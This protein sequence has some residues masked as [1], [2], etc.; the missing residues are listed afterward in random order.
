M[1]TTTRETREPR[2]YGNW[3]VPRAASLFGGGSFA[4]SVVLA[5]GLL[6]GIAAAVLIGLLAGLVVALLTLA[7]AGLVG[8]RNEHGVNLAQRAGERAAQ[9]RAERSGTNLYL[10]GPV[11]PLPYGTHQLPGVAAQTTMSEHVDAWGQPFALVHTPSSDDY[12]VAFTATPDGAALVAVDVFDTMVAN[13]GGWLAGHALEADL[14]GA[15]L[16]FESRPDL[17]HRLAAEVAG[18]GGRGNEV[19][20]AV[21]AE[22]V[23][24]LPTGGAVTRAWA[25]TTFSATPRHDRSRK[26]STAEVAADLAVRVPLIGDALRSAGATSTRPTP[27]GELCEVI[28][29]A[30]DPA[31]AAVLEQAR[32]EG[33]PEVLSWDDVGPVAHDAGWDWYRHDGG[34]SVS[35]YMS[36]PPKGTVRAT[37]LA[38]LL[39]PHPA[40][41]VKRVALLY[42]PLDLVEAGKA[43]EHDA[44]HADHAV[45]NPPRGGRPTAAALAEQRRTIQSANEEAAGAAVL[46]FAAVITATVTDREQLRQARAVVNQ[47]SHGAKLLTR[48]AYAAQAT[49]FAFGLPLGLIPTHHAALPT[50]V[51]ERL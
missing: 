8:F 39:A 28:R 34:W 11:S 36:R 21:M 44:H 4:G 19:S 26:R 15:S 25:T 6:V 10:S 30:Y 46:N 50:A 16:V 27:G 22:L 33:A 12:A 7:G 14:V 1:T 38:R 37:T 40:I 13:Y 20:R 42:R 43:V 48:P 45:N 35:W 9:A 41:A 32:A 17:G 51:K 23:A 2:D 29:A 31:A 47:L 24:Q 3:G 5:G 18:N 49:A